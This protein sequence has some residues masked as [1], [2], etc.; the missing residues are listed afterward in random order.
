MINII[1]TYEDSFNDHTRNNTV[2]ITM[3][4]QS[5]NDGYFETKCKLLIAPTVL[6]VI[7][8][9][10]EGTGFKK[11]PFSTIFVQS[12]KYLAFTSVVS[13][14][15]LQQDN[16]D[17]NCLSFGNGTFMANLHCIGALSSFLS[18]NTKIPA[19]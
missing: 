8:Y 18:T 17:F 2:T 12:F 15:D 19:S 4:L 16:D 1:N 6:A 10:E 5:F 9:S 7:T 3:V 11:Q 14:E 13:D